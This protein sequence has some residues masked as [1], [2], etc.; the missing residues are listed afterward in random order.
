MKIVI[1][2]DSF[3]GAL[4]SI[5]IANAMEEGIKRTLVDVEI[6]KVPMADGGEGTVEAMVEATG[7]RMV[8][9]D[10]TGPLGDTVHSFYGILGDGETAVIEMAAA[11]GLPLVPIDQRNPLYTTTYG[12]GELIKHAIENKCT[13][14]MMGIGG[15]ATNDGGMG[16]A[17]AL[18][19]RFFDKEG[20]KL[21][22][23]GKE[24]EKIQQIDMSGI[25]PNIA[26]VEIKVACDVTNPLWGERG[27]AYVFGPQKG[28]NPEIVER[29]D[30]GLKHLSSVIQKEL[31]KEIADLPG[32]GAAGGLGGGLVAFLNARLESGVQMVI[33][34]SKL[35][36]KIKNADLVMTGEGKTDEQTA[37]GK[38]PFGVA[39]IAKKY[40]VPVVCLSGAL[41]EGAEKLYDHGITALFS[42]V[43]KDMSLKEAMDH[44]DELVKNA[45]ENIVRLFVATN[46]K[47]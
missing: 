22:L 34:S 2:P 5:K 7:G 27:A 4:S 45:S 19:V 17:Q 30:K 33:R 47:K 36:E 13:K 18:G 23:G 44:T 46:I 24:L 28:A 25:H 12:T 42:A 20:N 26:D 38:V 40:N 10:V 37:F 1:A 16:M 32:A 14:V 11:S 31:G 15:S 9:T 35:E 3:K 41:T 39:Q 43:N 29:L 8:Y 6:I 21:A